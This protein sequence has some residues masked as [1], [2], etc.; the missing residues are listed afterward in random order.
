MKTNKYVFAPWASSTSAAAAAA[1]G[2]QH[3][4]YGD[5]NNKL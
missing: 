1:A 2:P 5:N 3:I 4:S